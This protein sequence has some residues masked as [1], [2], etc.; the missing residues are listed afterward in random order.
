MTK[1]TI[2]EYFKRLQLRSDWQSLL[3]DDMT[4]T[5]RTS[6]ARQLVGRD[7]YLSGTAR[8]FGM[9]V[10]TQVLDLIVD[11]EKACA[12]TRYRLQPPSG[13]ATFES[14]VAEIFSVSNGAITS[15]TIYFDSAPYPKPPK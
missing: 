7:A 4:F 5:S 15:L 14:D 13:G 6:P 9:I 10:D 1:D 2:V 11:G 3:A 12:L 8:F